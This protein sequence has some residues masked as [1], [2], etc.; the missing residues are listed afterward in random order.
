MGYH[1]SAFS[2]ALIISFDGGG[3][4]GVFNVFLGQGL[5]LKRIGNF[6][7]HFAGMYNSLQTL[8]P[9]V[10]GKHFVML[11]EL[12][13]GRWFEG[14]LDKENGWFVM[15]IHHSH[16]QM[17]FAGKLMGY[18]GLR[19]AGRLSHEEQAELEAYLDPF[20]SGQMDSTAN[21][22]NRFPPNLLRLSCSSKD[23]QKRLAAEMQMQFQKRFVQVVSKM[24]EQ[25]RLA[26]TYVE[27]IVLTGGCALNVLTNQLIRDTF[28]KAGI[29]GDLDM[30]NQPMRPSD[31]YVP[32]APNDAGLA[33]GGVWAAS[34]P[35]MVQSLQ[36]LGFKLFDEE[37]LDEVVRQRGALNL[38]DLGGV[39]YL[40]QLL[41]SNSS[42]SSNG[43]PIIAVVRGRQEF[44]PRALGHRSLLAVPDSYEIKA[45]CM[46]LVSS[47]CFVVLF[48]LLEFWFVGSCSCCSCCLRLLF[49]ML[50]HL[51]LGFCISTDHNKHPLIIATTHVIRERADDH[52]TKNRHFFPHDA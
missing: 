25:L 28:T 48:I 43:K 22:M 35:R 51:D 40:A 30:G 23:G 42:T 31:V 18:S 49:L 44:G 1:A 4:D 2:S 8:L 26:K 50:L 45:F 15:R 9:D 14:T 52:Q 27:G 47:I 33:V 11:H 13:C 19:K 20:L 17:D 39:D 10:S 37:I 12:I 16:V 41:T 32:S 21:Y 3:D 36:Y 34:P 5:E 24:L 29:K 38:N 46:N 7:A 6:D